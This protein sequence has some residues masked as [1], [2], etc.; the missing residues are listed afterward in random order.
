MA[1]TRQSFL[2]CAQKD[3]LGSGTWEDVV[4]G[5]GRVSSRF[6]ALSKVGALVRRS[7]FE[8][9][10]Y[11]TKVV[12]SN[13]FIVQL[14]I[15]LRTTWVLQF[16]EAHRWIGATLEMG[17]HTSL[18]VRA[19]LTLAASR[20]TNWEMALEHSREL[21]QEALSLYEVCGDVRGRA[22]A[23]FQVGDAWYMQGKYTLAT[24]YLE[25]TLNLQHE[26][27]EPRGAALTLRRLGAIATLQ[28]DFD[29]AEV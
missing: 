20:L 13:P 17:K 23:L 8:P 6:P 11:T 24:R 9:R 7:A 15:S 18:E 4:R 25:E 28:G 3:L 19:K 1:G 16:Q 14:K 26:L 10:Q 27:S 21:A 12:C 22:K 2:L 5:M 29:R